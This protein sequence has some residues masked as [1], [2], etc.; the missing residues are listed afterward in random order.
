MKLIRKTSLLRD[1]SG[2]TMVEG[3][4]AFTLLSIMLVIFSQGI[5]WAS[6]SEMNATKSRDGA[7]DAMISLQRDLAAGNEGHKGDDPIPVGS[8]SVI[9]HTYTYG[10]YQYTVYTAG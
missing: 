2:E 8:G 4:V 5:A 9:S 1:N 6:K 10:N 3:L 7:D